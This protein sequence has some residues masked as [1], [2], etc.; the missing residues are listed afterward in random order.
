V[1]RL[2]DISEITIGKEGSDGWCVTGMALVVN[3]VSIYSQ[4]FPPPC[5]RIDPPDARAKTTVAYSTL[6]QHASWASYTPLAAALQ[7]LGG[8][9]HG[10]MESIVE[11]N[12]GS[13]I[14][15]TDSH[16]HDGD[17]VQ[18]TKRSDTS[19]DVHA[20]LHYDTDYGDATV[21]V[22][23]SVEL[24]CS[25][26]R[27]S[28]TASPATVNV[29]LPWYLDVLAFLVEAITTVSI[30]LT[31]QIDL[32]LSST[33]D[34]GQPT[35]PALSIEADGDVNI[36]I[37]PSRPDV[38]LAISPST[39]RVRP[40]ESLRVA[41]TATNVGNVSSAAITSELFIAL[42]T[43]PLTTSLDNLASSGTRLAGGAHAAAPAC[44]APSTWSDPVQLPS[45]LKCAYRLPVFPS[46]P[47]PS[48]PTALPKR[49]DV[50]PAPVPRYYLV[51][52]VTSAGDVNA[53]NDITARMLEVGLADLVTSPIAARPVSV[54]AG[55]T[56]TVQ[57]GFIANAGLFASGPVRAR[58]FLSRTPGVRGAVHWWPARDLAA[59][60][61]GTVVGWGRAPLTIPPN[62]PAGPYVLGVFV[63]D[64]S[65]APECDLTNNVHTVPITIGP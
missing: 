41:A 35:C 10:D 49:E 17:G 22:D 26:G 47:M 37:P 28:V 45:S 18:V 4:E 25:C 12:I 2:G 46:K 34:T 48:T 38:A 42:G 16:W 20:D 40:G 1:S 13:Q 52:R 61:P 43:K 39:T 64:R 59:L 33:L 14:H 24:G 30:D 53:R 62:I 57:P 31:Q 55:G 9:K 8:I 29:D 63:E 23:F 15:G 65:G 21:D 7:L 27:V 50:L 58:F 36:G 19:L 54:N 56:V 51:E 11:G 32:A 3:G 6:R 5:L 60:P 44:G